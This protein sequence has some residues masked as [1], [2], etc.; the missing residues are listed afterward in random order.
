MVISLKKIT[1]INYSND[2]SLFSSILFLLFGIILFTNPGDI[3]KFIS[4]IA[5]GSLILI[6]IFN[7]ISYRRT[8]KKLNIEQKSKLISGVLLM[9]LGLFTILFSSLIETTI[10]LI[11]G[12]WI[13]YSGIMRLIDVLNN[14]ENKVSFIGRLIVAILLIICGLYVA[15]TDLVYSMIGLFI[16]IYA[17]LDIINSFILRKSSNI[18]VEI[19]TD[20][21]ETKGKRTKNAKVVKEVNKEDEE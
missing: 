1:I 15:L 21:K 16:I 14:K 19:S 17:I 13:I 20:R 8:L 9:I 5:G 2:N 6:G 12:G 7:V 11:F 18:S 10:R 3:L 4:Y